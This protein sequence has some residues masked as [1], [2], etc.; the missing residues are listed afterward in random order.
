MTF[1]EDHLYKRWAEMRNERD[2]MRSQRDG[3][4]AVL[5]A[6]LDLL[7]EYKKKLDKDWKAD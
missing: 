5:R 6:A 4:R 3:F 7:H 2:E 1:I